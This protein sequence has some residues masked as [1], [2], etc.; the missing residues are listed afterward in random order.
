MKPSVTTPEKSLIWALAK[1]RRDIEPAN[2]SRLEGPIDLA[3]LDLGRELGSAK[4]IVIRRPLLNQW[5]HLK[6][7]QLNLLC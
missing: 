2:A 7:I 4:T 3:G 6:E 1:V 5:A